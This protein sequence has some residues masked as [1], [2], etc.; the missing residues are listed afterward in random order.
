M[1]NF[2]EF[3]AGTRYKLLKA[4]RWPSYVTAYGLTHGSHPSSKTPSAG[5]FDVPTGTKIMRIKMAKLE[6]SNSE[7]YIK[8]YFTMTDD[9]TSPA[10]TNDSAF[11]FLLITGNAKNTQ[12]YTAYFGQGQREHIDIEPSGTEIR[13]AC[14]DQDG[15]NSATLNYPLHIEFYGVA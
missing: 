12:Q 3:T 6:G 14:N 7:Q 10:S 13:I 5:W 4:P 2:S 1:S 15:G 8:H 11:R 9:G